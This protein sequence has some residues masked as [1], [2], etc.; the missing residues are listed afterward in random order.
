MNKIAVLFPSFLGGGA[1]AVCAWMLEALKDKDVILFT[2]SNISLHEL[3]LQFGTALKNSNIQVRTI[4][5]PFPGFLGNKIKNSESAFALRQYYLSWYFRRYLCDKCNICISGFNEMDFGKPGI[6]YIHAPMFGKDVEVIRSVLGHPDSSF[7]HIFRQVL[8]LATKWSDKRVRSNFT[9]VNSHWTANWV[10]RIH[11]VKANVIYPPVTWSANTKTWQERENGFVLVSRIVREKKIER[12]IRILE[13]VRNMGFP[14]RLHVLGGLG[15]NSYMQELLVQFR[16]HE[17]IKWEKRL[18]RGEYE[19]TL[20]GYRYGIHPRNNE[21][22]GI[23]VAEMVRAG[24]IPFVPDEG[25]QA[26]IIDHDERL[27]WKDE[28]D[29]VQKII[30]VLNNTEL[31]HELRK[32]LWEWSQRFSAEN[33]ITAFRQIIGM[34]SV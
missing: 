18:T 17:W 15:N 23:G 22:F 2:Y 4:L 10:L 19:H 16:K 3:D 6:Q 7:R 13:Q 8:R 12:A 26:E 33:F 9:I 5:L 21:Q 30:N 34:F 28:N 11:G 24:I 14:V 31:Q 29:A 25:G 27:C 20:V 1:E 32:K